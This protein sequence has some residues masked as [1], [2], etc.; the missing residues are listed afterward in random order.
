MTGHYLSGR[1]GQSA[2]APLPTT[3]G[4][5]LEQAVADH[6]DARTG[7]VLV[8]PGLPAAHQRLTVLGQV[9]SRLRRIF[10]N[11]ASTMSGW[12]AARRCNGSGAM[13]FDCR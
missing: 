3:A 8:V 11:T 9:K 1:C 7:L 13:V 4:G 2:F 5:E 10:R 6:R 12:A